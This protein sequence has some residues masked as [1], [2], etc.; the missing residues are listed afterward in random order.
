[1]QRQSPEAVPGSGVSDMGTS[2]QNGVMQQVPI[3]WCPRGSRHG[4]PQTMQG[5][6][7]AA[8]L[9]PQQGP[10]ASPAFIRKSTFTPGTLIAGF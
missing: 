5:W 8:S 4:H 9:E 2:Q 10:A 1:M 6:G 7:A 3:F